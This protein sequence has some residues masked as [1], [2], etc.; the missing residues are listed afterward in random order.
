MV[1]STYEPPQMLLYNAKEVLAGEEYCE[2]IG[3]NYVANPVPIRTFE[4]TQG[5]SRRCLYM[6]GPNRLIFAE[7][8][9]RHYHGPCAYTKCDEQYV[10]SLK[11]M[12]FWMV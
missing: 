2:T 11:C 12:D 6:A 4:Y 9:R 5:I 1:L 7:Q 8:R 10:G 3:I